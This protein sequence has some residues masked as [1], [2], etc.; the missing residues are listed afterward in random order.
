MIIKVSLY[1]KN[2]QKAKVKQSEEP[3]K[4]AFT[5]SKLTIKT[6]DRRHWCQYILVIISNI[7]LYNI[8]W[9]TES[10]LDLLDQNFG[11]TDTRK[12]A[13]LDDIFLRMHS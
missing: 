7:T 9:Y 12:C 6:Q 3:S 4:S 8:F 10:F 13:N 2:W 1:I 5:C 11:V